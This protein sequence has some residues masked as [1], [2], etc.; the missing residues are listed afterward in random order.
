MSDR[1][2]RTIIVQPE[3]GL[4]VPPVGIMTPRQRFALRHPCRDI[5]D[6]ND[7]R[8]RE[9]TTLVDNREAIV[10]LTF[11]W[12][13]NSDPIWRAGFALRKNG[14]GILRNDFTHNDVELA[15]RSMKAVLEGVG[16]GL[17]RGGWLWPSPYGLHI[18]RP[19]S[20]RERDEALIYLRRKG[21]I[22]DAFPSLKEVIEDGRIEPLDAVGTRSRANDAVRIAIERRTIQTRQ[23][24]KVAE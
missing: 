13:A 22:P 19:T 1:R 21:P 15:V 6:C 3:A 10:T 8:F 17:L 20:R 24:T 16:I 12:F 4:V 18:K 2:D 11:E 9:R 23:A 5:R 7:E 14:E